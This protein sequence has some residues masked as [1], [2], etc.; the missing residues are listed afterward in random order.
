VIEGDVSEKELLGVARRLEQFREVLARGFGAGV[1]LTTPTPLTVVVFARQRTFKPVQPLYNGKA[2]RVGG[3]AEV[4]N[5]GTSIAI[6]LDGG[7]QVYAAIYHEYAHLLISN[8]IA[9]APAWLNE[10]LAEFYG[11]FELSS[12]GRRAEL[13][14]P[15]LPAR[16]EGLRARRLPLSDVLAAD[17][18]TYARSADRSLLYAQSW[19]LV[20]YLTLGNPARARQYADFI[21]RLRAGTPADAA[22]SAAFPDRYKLEAEV[23]DYVNQY[24]VRTAEVR[25][26]EKVAADVTY[27]ATPMRPAEVEATFG[28]LLL[29]QQRHAEAE[30]RFTRAVALDPAT[31]TAHTGLG[32]L[33]MM[34]GK[35]P[36][37]LAPLWKGVELADGD[38]MAHFALGIAALRCGS[39]QCAQQRG[40]VQTARRELQRAVEILPEFPE[41][42]SS[43]ATAELATATDLSSAERH[44]LDAVG[45]LP[46][47]DDYRYLLAK[48]YTSQRNY[49]K[50]RDVLVRLTQVSQGTEWKAMARS[51][52]AELARAENAAQAPAAAAS[53]APPAAGSGATPPPPQ[54]KPNLSGPTAATAQTADIQFDSKDVEFGPWLRRFI[55]TVKRNWVMPLAVMTTKGH[56]VVTFKVRKDGRITDINVS[57]PAGEQTFNTAARAAIESSSPVAPLPPEYPNDTCFFQVTFYYNEAP[58]RRPVVFPGGTHTAGLR[59]ELAVMEKRPLAART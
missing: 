56:V 41:A 57:V 55:A 16:I 40:G 32:L 30:A 25:F 48:I 50:A 1:R 33:R 17:E 24:S 45:L 49:P 54:S 39:E 47:R 44:A 14:R 13:G 37:A 9:G 12:D 19:A 35:G 52:L 31:A 53:A 18:D 29:R 7:T 26:S 2:E 34:Q 22:F 21:G 46:G 5:I 51:R 3:Y 23:A 59:T 11:T 27:R 58:I 10:G 8:A 28:H 38:A 36:E 20:H 6:S 4:T 43:L 15:I 42:L